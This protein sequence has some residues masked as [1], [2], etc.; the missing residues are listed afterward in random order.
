MLSEFNDPSPA[1]LDEVS[2]DFVYLTKQQL[3][4]VM[5]HV[6]QH[7]WPPRPTRQYK[8]TLQWMVIRAVRAGRYKFDMSHVPDR[9]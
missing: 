3:L 2:P 5:E 7:F 6:P 8:R 4:Y 1:E 9:S